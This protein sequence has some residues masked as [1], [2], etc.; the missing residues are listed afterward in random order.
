MKADF[1]VGMGRNLAIAE[2]ASHSKLAE[3]C[4][5]SHLTMI[6]SQNLSRDVYSMMTIAAL[7]THRIK[8]GHGVTNPF[9]RHPS[10]TATAS[11]TINEVSGGRAFV[12]IGAGFSSVMTM[13]MNARTMQEFRET[14][15]FIK[16]YTAGREVEYHGSKMHSEWIRR[17]VPVYMAS[18][19]LRSLRMAGELADG[20]MLGG[21]HPEMMKWNLEQIA[22]GAESVG[23]DPGEIDIWARTEILVA[24]S[25]E[26]ARREVA[27]Y[28]MSWACG[29]YGS[30]F[31]RNAPEIED[32]RQRI[33]RAEP[34]LLDEMRI[35]YEAFDPYQHEKTD[36]D[37]AKLASQRLIDFFLMPGTPDDIGEQISGVLPLGVNNI[38]TVLFTIIDK[39]GMIRR[40]NREIMPMFSD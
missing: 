12:G 28:A 2:V 36:A 38:S 5:F 11:A 37:H 6:D 7:N 32:L 4:G 39:K 18:I 19:G 21:V 22:R 15:Q 17:P 34:G 33:E 24:D 27:S 9:T 25:K 16:D 1:S 14:V 30:L 20:V 31:R 26:E 13:G 10:V 40:I 35:A 8:I 29:F 3:D 23:R